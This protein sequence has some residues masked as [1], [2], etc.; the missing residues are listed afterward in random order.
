M[1]PHVCYS[2]SNDEIKRM[3][4]FVSTNV[5]MAFIII[6]CNGDPLLVNETKLTLSGLKNGYYISDFF[7]GELT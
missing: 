3:K 7:G 4:E 6:P 5:L 1:N 2:I